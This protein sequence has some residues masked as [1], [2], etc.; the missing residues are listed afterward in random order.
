MELASQ[1]VVTFLC[2]AMDQTV[3]TTLMIAV[4]GQVN[5]KVAPQAGLDLQQEPQQWRACRL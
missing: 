4:P 3:A 5:S 1:T 2:V